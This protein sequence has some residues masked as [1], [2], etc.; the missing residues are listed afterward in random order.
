[1]F[2]SKQWTL[3][4]WRAPINRFLIFFDCFNSFKIVHY[5]KLKRSFK[6][7]LWIQVVDEFP[8]PHGTAKVSDLFG[9]KA[10]PFYVLIDKEGKVILSSDD[11]VLIKKKIEKIFNWPLFARFEGFLFLNI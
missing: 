8:D 4:K 3:K 6:N 10:F 9:I 5:F 11:E 7:W 1:M 2:V